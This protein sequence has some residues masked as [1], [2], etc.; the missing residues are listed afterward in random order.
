[1]MSSSA[2]AIHLDLNREKQFCKD[3]SN[4]PS[5]GNSLSAYFLPS[6]DGDHQSSLKSGRHTN[7]ER[8][9]AQ[10]IAPQAHPHKG[11]SGTPINL[12]EDVHPL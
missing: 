6:R 12:W 5:D 4:G 1:M 8:E 10:R 11:E 9:P 7:D 3:A 2:S